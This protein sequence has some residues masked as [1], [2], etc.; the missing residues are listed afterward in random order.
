MSTC[1][2]VGISTPFGTA[3]FEVWVEPN[4]GLVRL[5]SA[6][7]PWLTP[8]DGASDQRLSLCVSLQKKA[9]KQPFVIEGLVYVGCKDLVEAPRSALQAT[10][11]RHYLPSIQAWL[12]EN[13]GTLQLIAIRQMDE[14]LQELEQELEEAQ[15]NLNAAREDL[16]EHRT[17][18]RDLYGVDIGYISEEP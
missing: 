15:R 1:D 14:E 8:V 11:E 16:R 18:M 9:L 4:P 5:R 3:T 10:V 17:V 6:F 13:Q 12:D 2:Y 7:F